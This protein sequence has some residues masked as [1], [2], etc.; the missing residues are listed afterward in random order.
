MIKYCREMLGIDWVV[1]QVTDELQAEGRLDNTLLVFTADNGM[2]WGAHRA[3]QKKSLPYTTPVPL[4]FSFPARWGDEPRDVD[5]LVVNIDLAPTFCD[6]AGD[7]CHLGPYPG[8][9]AGPDGVSML[10]LLDDPPAPWRSAAI[11][12][13]FLGPNSEDSGFTGWRAIRTDETHPLGAWHYVEWA[14]GF[15]ELYD[16][17]ADPWELT[18]KANDPT[19]LVTRT[20]LAVQLETLWQEG[21]PAD[22]VMRPDALIAKDKNGIHYGSHI[23]ADG[24]STTQS[25]TYSKAPATIEKSYFVQVLNRNPD[26]GSF[27]FNGSATGAPSM[28]VKYIRNGIDVTADVNG[29]G[30]VVS[31]VRPGNIVELTIKISANNA[32]PKTTKT[33][34]LTVRNTDAMDHLDVV[35]AI[36]TRM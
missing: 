22:E 2:A 28:N 32:A 8:G 21:R 33:A 4:Y 17:T 5:D 1:K 26:F 31:N 35:K 15:R 24:P 13:H 20:Q 14:N 34:V 9:Q 7:A 29:S 6:I 27:T 19:K 25:M 12:E 23:Y 18:N 30:L 11:E 36:L 10:P 16:L 3:A